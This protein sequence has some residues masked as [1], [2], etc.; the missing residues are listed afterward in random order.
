MAKS[1]SGNFQKVVN[2]REAAESK[3][4]LIEINHPDLVTPVR[5]V[6]AVEDI[7]SNGETYIGFA[8]N[9][10]GVVD[11]EVGLGEA[12]IEL[13]NLGREFLEFLQNADLRKPTEFTIRE[14]LRSSPD[15]VEFE[16][17]MLV[18]DIAY[19]RD[20]VLIRLS[21]GIRVDQ[22]LTRVPYDMQNS[23]GL[24]ELV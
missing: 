7:V 16:V 12:T 21:F 19:D 6:N 22:P 10:T 13:D 1:L 14:L 20:G 11:P 8:F 5:V 9:F 17:V 2:S 23:P 24:F 3:L 15:D 18:D 4:T